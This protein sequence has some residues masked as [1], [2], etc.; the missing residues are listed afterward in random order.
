M[1]MKNRLMVCVFLQESY[2][3]NGV[4]FHEG[5]AKE[6]FASPTDSC[7]VSLSDTWVAQSEDFSSVMELC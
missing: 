7:I 2:K 5:Y 4:L 6:C 1:A 3:S